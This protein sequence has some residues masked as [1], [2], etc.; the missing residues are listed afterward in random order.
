MN[1]K[2]TNETTSAKPEK[3][4]TFTTTIP[5]VTFAIDAK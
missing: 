5:D 1:R 3:K 2:C 4:M